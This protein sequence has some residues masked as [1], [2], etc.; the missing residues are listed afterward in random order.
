[1]LPGRARMRCVEDTP[2]LAV[3]AQLFVRA[4]LSDELV[5]QL[6]RVRTS[7]SRHR[8][9]PRSGPDWLHQRPAATISPGGASRGQGV[10]SATS[11]VEPGCGSM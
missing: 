6:T 4:D 2:T 5:F 11:W 7:N 10:P 3:G 9:G 1:M 8:G